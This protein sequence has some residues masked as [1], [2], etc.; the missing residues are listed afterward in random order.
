MQCEFVATRTLIY[1]LDINNEI[2]YGV[3]IFSQFSINMTSYAGELQKLSNFST[4]SLVVFD[5]VKIM[6]SPLRSTIPAFLKILA[7]LKAAPRRSSSSNPIGIVYIT[8]YELSDEHVLL[9][10]DEWDDFLSFLTI[11]N[12]SQMESITLPTRKRSTPRLY[13]DSQLRDSELNAQRRRRRSWRRISSAHLQ[14]SIPRD[15][16]GQPIGTSR[17]L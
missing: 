4:N 5:W 13:A 11:S 8:P 12:H 16:I 17:P 7:F 10:C 2:N 9:T 6:E 15:P 14:W 3:N 1:F